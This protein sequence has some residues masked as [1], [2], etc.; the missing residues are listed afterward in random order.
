M[1]KEYDFDAVMSA[2]SPRLVPVSQHRR[3]AR[4]SGRHQQHG[5]ILHQR[6]LIPLQRYQPPAAGGL[7]RD[8]RRHSQLPPRGHVQCTGLYG[9]QQRDPTHRDRRLQRCALRRTNSPAH[10]CWRFIA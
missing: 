10:T 9:Q 4:P 6:P 5:A 7:H 8:P 2:C 3:A 1:A